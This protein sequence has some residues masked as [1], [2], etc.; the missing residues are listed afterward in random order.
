MSVLQV[1]EEHCCSWVRM[2][3]LGGSGDDD[4]VEFARVRWRAQ[5][6][7][8]GQVWADSER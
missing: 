7:A 1:G 2:L 3:G 8:W 6:P 4:L 5:A